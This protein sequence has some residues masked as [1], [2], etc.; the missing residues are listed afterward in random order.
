MGE[1]E[2]EI[3]RKS[4]IPIVNPEWDRAF[5]SDIA[6]GNAEGVKN[7]SYEETERGGGFGGHEILI[8]AAVM[9]SMAG[10]G[11]TVLDYQEVPEW[12]TGIGYAIYE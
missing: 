5:L 3:A 11:A 1:F 6:K 10:Q 4:K 2:Q 12:I 8:W 7:R 9:G